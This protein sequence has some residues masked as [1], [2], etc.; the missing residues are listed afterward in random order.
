MYKLGA[1]EFDAMSEVS[2][3]IGSLNLVQSCRAKIQS[4]L[5]LSKFD[6]VEICASALSI[7]EFIAGMKRHQVKR[8][9]EN[10]ESSR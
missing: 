8:H 2:S 9:Q 7:N 10:A 5:T 4:T 3:I 1:S 6:P